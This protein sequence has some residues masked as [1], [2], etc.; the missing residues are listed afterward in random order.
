MAASRREHRPKVLAA[1]ASGA[2]DPDTAVRA[3]EAMRWMDRL[4]YHTRRAIHHLRER[5][6]GEAP[7]PTST[8]SGPEPVGAAEAAAEASR[9]G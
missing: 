3:L 6:Q 8:F 9:P 4:A 1:T 5:P 7:A 2:I